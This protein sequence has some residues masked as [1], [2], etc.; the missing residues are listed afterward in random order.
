MTSV[1]RTIVL[2]WPSNLV[3]PSSKPGPGMYDRSRRRCEAPEVLE[4]Q[5]AAACNNLIQVQSPNRRA[6]KFSIWNADNKERQLVKILAT[7]IPYQLHARIRAPNP[8]ISVQLALRRPVK[9][10]SRIVG[11]N[12]PKILTRRQNTKEPG[13]KPC[14]RY[15]R[16]IGA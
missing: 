1:R 12:S 10:M 13:P 6:F 14:T 7:G 16:T 9:Q 11:P 3:A 15:S 4:K 8:R 5:A 2:P